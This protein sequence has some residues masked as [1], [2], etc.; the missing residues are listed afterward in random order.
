MTVNIVISQTEIFSNSAAVLEN[1]YANGETCLLN[2]S[3]MTLYA[4]MV[5]VIVVVF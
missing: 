4:A 1:L 3:Q 5:M 2:K